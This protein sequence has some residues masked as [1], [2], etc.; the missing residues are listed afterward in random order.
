MGYLDLKEEK[1]RVPYRCTPAFQTDS[2]FQTFA[3]EQEVA[4]VVA[5]GAAD[6]AAAVGQSAGQAAAV[7]RSK[8]VGAAAA[9]ERHFKLRENVLLSAGETDLTC[10]NVS[11]LDRPPC[12]GNIYAEKTAHEL[13]QREEGRRSALCRVVS[14]MS[15]LSSL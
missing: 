1:E 13:R 14:H 12:S 7:E 11:A 10:T 4:H 8:C 3:A 9:E 2:S 5:E 15:W 6:V